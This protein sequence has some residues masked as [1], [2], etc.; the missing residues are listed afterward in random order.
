MG[1]SLYDVTWFLKCSFRR[2]EWFE[3]WFLHSVVSQSKV[4]DTPYTSMHIFSDTSDTVKE[5][6][7]WNKLSP[8]CGFTERSSWNFPYTCL[9]RE[10]KTPNLLKQEVGW[11]V[12]S[13]LF[14][15]SWV[16]GPFFIVPSVSYQIP[17]LVKKD[18]SGKVVFPH[19]YFTKLSTGQFPYS[20]LH[21]FSN[22][23]D[24]VKQEVGWKTVSPLCF[25]HR[26][27]IVA[28]SLYIVLWKCFQTLLA[29]KT[30]VEGRILD[31]VLIQQFEHIALSFYI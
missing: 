3:R 20:S 27:E 21:R 16:Y 24:P 8:W 26:V 25:F 9:H 15:Q 7:S 30:L 12:V 4:H 18:V 28:L 29:N 2:K 1:L 22:K 14:F 19:C 23:S 11:K 17:N 13:P 5:T 10:S 31:K 6:G